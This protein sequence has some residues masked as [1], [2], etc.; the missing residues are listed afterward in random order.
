MFVYKL[1]NNSKLTYIGIT[2][3]MKMRMKTHAE[4]R[5]F[6]YVE[7]IQVK[8]RYEAKIIEEYLINTLK[9][10]ENAVCNKGSLYLWE[11]AYE[12]HKYSWVVYEKEEPKSSPA[13]IP[14][15]TLLLK[16]KEVFVISE[17]KVYELS[18]NHKIVYSYLKH[19]SEGKD[20]V[21]KYQDIAKN[22]GISDR[23]ALSLVHLLCNAKLVSKRTVS[24]AYGFHSNSYIVHDILDN[25]MFKE[26]NSS[27][28]PRLLAL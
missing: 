21:I 5:K 28:V 4:T 15:L 1:Y 23:A 12:A 13:F 24:V 2:K 9:P 16:I 18:G 27:K 7:Y 22:C 26:D 19:I 25:T 11:R 10:T 17:N 8:D 14:V 20:I 6:D 3:N